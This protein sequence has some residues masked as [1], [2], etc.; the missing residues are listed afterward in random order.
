[1]PA[2]HLHIA[3]EV[4][5]EIREG[6]ARLR[7]S[8]EVPE[9]FPDAVLAQVRER[10]ASG[11][12]DL[13]ERQDLT[14]IEFVTI[15]PEG[16]M[17]LDQAMFIERAVESANGAA[18]TVWY[19][20]ADVAAWVAPGGAIDV[21]AHRRGQTFYAPNERIP[22]HP[23]EVSE[24]AASLLDD[25]TP[26]PALVWKI[27]LDA[28]GNQVTGTVVRATVRSRERLSYVQVQGWLDAGTAPEWAQLLR[29]VGTLRQRLEAARGGVSL[30]LPEQEITADERGW[31]LSYRAPLPVE[32]WNA[33]ISLL[34]GMAAAKIML[35]GGVGIL[36]TLPQAE[37][38]AVERLRR[39][40]RSLHI[41]WP[42]DMGYPDFVRSL[43]VSQPTH[44][45]MM[46]AC[47]ALFRGAGYTLVAAGVDPATVQHGALAANY[48][49]TTAPLRRLVDRYVGEICV[50]LCAGTAVPRW[51][52]DAL[53]ALPD[54]MRDSD[55]RSKKF[56]RGNVDLVEALV[57]SQRVGQVFAAVVVELDQKSGG[58][59]SIEHPAIEARLKADGLELGSE[60]S[61]RLESVDLV[62]GKVVLSRV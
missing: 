10:V 30:N 26:R 28:Q 37:P 46:T 7:E 11:P 56:E 59:V 16:S 25:G 20:I 52:L 22:L 23:S 34:T 12:L 42:T 48:A 36:R 17:D 50:H 29:E 49:H 61:V 24:Q 43:D 8:L 6:I 5:E 62:T 35:D 53:A 18:F 3:A 27:E 21:E 51:T 33:Q 1:M 60:V 32:D 9:G 47:T 45:A 13:G 39:T 38:S 44:L 15:D 54:E 4:P 14:A 31:H 19:A 40:A 55:S 2:R 58:T 57:M 41:D